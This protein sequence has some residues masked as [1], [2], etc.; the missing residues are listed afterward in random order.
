MTARLALAVDG[1]RRAWLVEPAG[2]EPTTARHGREIVQ[3]RGKGSMAV[4]TLL[5]VVA[6]FAG[7][8]VV[9][10]LVAVGAAGAAWYM[11]RKR[12]A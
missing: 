7:C 12:P 2:A 11:G 4:N 9:T 8:V 3:R 6:G 5:L 10:A 1:H